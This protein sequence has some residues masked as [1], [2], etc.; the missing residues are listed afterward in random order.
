M[1]PRLTI[2]VSL[3]DAARLN[4]LKPGTLIYDVTLDWERTGFPIALIKS[5]QAM[6][7]DPAFLLQWDAASCIP[8]V[9]YHYF[10]FYANAIQQAQYAWS[11]VRHDFT[12]MD[13]LAIDFEHN[14]GSGR[15]N[16]INGATLQ[17]LGSMMYEL[18]KVI[19]AS[20]LMIYTGTSFWY[21]CGGKLAAWA[22]KYKHWQAQW[23]WD[24]FLINGKVALPPYVWPEKLL[25][26]KV[27][28]IDSGYA[29]PVEC[30]PWGRPDIW[31][32]S[33]RLDP[34]MIPSY[35]PGK[36]A[37][38]VN[39]VYMDIVPAPPVKRCAACGQVIP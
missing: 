37:V 3:Y 32:F 16:P 8:R 17:A 4:P 30:L 29:K 38:D 23:P 9:A 24:N 34:K 14:L 31:Q 1:H 26:E 18:E 5:S 15:Y 39:Y 13:I 10:D 11:V 20:Q 21:P 36:K 12:K 33:A 19:P 25:N 28:L 27:A 22:K 2:D 6:F 35:P 7:T